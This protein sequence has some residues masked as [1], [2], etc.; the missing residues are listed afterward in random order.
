MAEAWV[1]MLRLRDGRLYT[2]WAVDPLQ[3]LREHEA[4]RGSRLVRPLLPAAIVYLEEQPDRGAALRREAAIKALRRAAKLELIA[5]REAA[6][7]SALARWAA[8]A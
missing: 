4:G 8:G 2:G 6:T 3:R 5:G 1:Y 7:R